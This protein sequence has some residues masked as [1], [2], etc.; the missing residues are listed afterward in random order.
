MITV[1][2]VENRLDGHHISYLS[3]LT[4]M[5][6]EEFHPIL[7][8]PENKELQNWCGIFNVEYEIMVREEYLSVLLQVRE[9][10]RKWSINI[11]H[12]VYADAYFR[13]AGIGLWSLGAVK[14]V[15]TFHQFRRSKLRD[16]VRKAIFKKI[17]VGVVHTIILHDLVMGEGTKN[18]HQINYPC[19]MKKIPLTTMQAR[20]YLG[21][22]TCYPVLLSLGGTRYDK[23]I[24]ILLNALEQVK[25][26]FFLIIAGVESTFTSEYIKQHSVRFE[27]N[28]L[29]KLRYLSEKEVS[30]FVLA[31]DW[32]VLPYR[33]QFDGASGP[34]GEGVVYGKG[35]IGPSHGSLGEIISNN[36]LGYVFEAENT[37]H[38][39]DT[40]TKALKKPFMID[41][42]Y[43]YYQSLLDV[44]IFQQN[45]MK[46]YQELM[47]SVKERE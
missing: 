32:I 8:A 41:D 44:R 30:L 23:G 35:I 12:F 26:P 34:L 45:Y 5:N 40:I 42:N 2:F 1:L 13:F 17:D 9:I 10:Q 39:A 16:I 36:H 21:V 46:L 24:D 18:V 19:F 33:K 27:N 37:A 7:L 47:Q 25:E 38:L 28:T 6:R 15:M 22:K 43:K 3:S 11:V 29:L 14:I 20:E 4:N 31:S